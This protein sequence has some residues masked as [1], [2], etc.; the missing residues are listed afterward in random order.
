MFHLLLAF[1]LAGWPGVLVWLLLC[2]GGHHHPTAT[3]EVGLP[4]TSQITLDHG[5]AICAWPH[6]EHIK[7]G[8]FA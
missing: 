3:A 2:G 6:N 1:L 4:T 7:A 8:P 5:Q